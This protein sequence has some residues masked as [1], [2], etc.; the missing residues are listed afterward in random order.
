LG[1]IKKK[2]MSLSNQTIR[3]EAQLPLGLKLY[4]TGQSEQIIRINK[5]CHHGRACPQVADGNV[6][7]L[8]RVTANILNK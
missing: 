8:W 6:L 2:E 3:E 5:T 4:N 1:T 7:Q